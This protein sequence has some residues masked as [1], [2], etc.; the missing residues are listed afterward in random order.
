M[1]LFEAFRFLLDFD[2]FGHTLA[3]R[4]LDGLWPF[5]F[6]KPTASGIIKQLFSYGNRG[7]GFASIWFP[8][9]SE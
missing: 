1:P 6:D 8:G 7:C 9:D 3:F 5:P 4:L 2:I